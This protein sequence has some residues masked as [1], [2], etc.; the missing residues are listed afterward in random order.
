ML[1][2]RVEERGKY[3][4]E[5]HAGSGEG[6]G[7]VAREGDEVAREGGEGEGEG[8]GGEEGGEVA[9]EGGEVAGGGGSDY[10]SFC[11]DCRG[12][13]MRALRILLHEEEV[14]EC[15]GDEDDGEGEGDGDEVD[16]EEMKEKEEAEAKALE[17]LGGGQANEYMEE[18]WDTP[19][20]WMEHGG[21]NVLFIN[22][23][24]IINYMYVS[25]YLC[26]SLAWTC[27]PPLWV[28]LTHITSLSAPLK[29]FSSSS[30][31]SHHHHLS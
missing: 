9:R 20:G 11:Q 23:H 15:D 22:T 19:H 2:E 18:G 10:P 21:V 26:R 29:V 30:S 8:E 14:G 31:S 4:G 13:L 28:Y 27:T 6:G 1:R 17:A 5:D 25:L 24:Q 16:V 12:N 3:R 7:E